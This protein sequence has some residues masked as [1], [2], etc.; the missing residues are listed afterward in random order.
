[1]PL[2]LPTSVLPMRLARSPERSTASSTRAATVWVNGPWILGKGTLTI[3]PA[4]GLSVSTIQVTLRTKGLRP[5]SE[6]PGETPDGRRN[7]TGTPDRA[8]VRVLWPGPSGPAPTMARG[9]QAAL[10]LVVRRCRLN[11]RISNLAAGSD[12]PRSRL[13]SCRDALGSPCSPTPGCRLH[14]NHLPPEFRWLSPAEIEDGFAFSR[15]RSCTWLQRH[16]DGFTPRSR[17]AHS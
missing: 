7:C 17:T 5:P 8:V 10:R 11:E 12:F 2:W 6:K 4:F 1:M 9:W 13:P 3:P 16:A 14:E 15:R